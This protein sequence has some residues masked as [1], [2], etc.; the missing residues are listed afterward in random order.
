MAKFLVGKNECRYKIIPN[1]IIEFKDECENGLYKYTPLKAKTIFKYK[2]KELIY[3]INICRDERC[4][5]NNEANRF[6]IEVNNIYLEMI[7][8]VG[9]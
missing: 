7:K 5:T 2:R 6:I 3:F 4:I 9:V 1:K 8:L